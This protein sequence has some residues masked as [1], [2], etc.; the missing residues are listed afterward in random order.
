MCEEIIETILHFQIIGVIGIILTLVAIYFAYKASKKHESY[1]KQILDLKDPRQVKKLE[2]HEAI[3]VKDYLKTETKRKI[4]DVEGEIKK[5]D[6][7]PKYSHLLTTI[8]N[9]IDEF[10][11]SPKSGTVFD[12]IRTE[13]VDAVI[14]NIDGDIPIELKVY[15]KRIID[16]NLPP[17]LVE[18]MNYIMRIMRTNESVLI[19]LSPGI[20]DK[21]R[22]RIET[23]FLP[24]KIK[25]I[26]GKNIDEI[27][28]EFRKYL[29][30]KF[31]K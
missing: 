22:N 1:F 30:S 20:E 18:Q 25:L 31:K 7:K 9:E 6:V 15:P 29:K 3:Q 4:L 17:R 2:L 12:G 27:I 23:M 8:A 5:Y 11:L 24:K 19:I 10:G 26:H 28:P 16:N 21:A 13:H 14:E